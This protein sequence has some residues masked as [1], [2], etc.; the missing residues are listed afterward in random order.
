MI[1]ISFIIIFP[2]LIGK[3]Y[4][5]NYSILKY[6]L[7]KIETI[8]ISIILLLTLNYQ[9]SVFAIFVLVLILILRY[10]KK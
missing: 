4:K 6:D 7:T 9:N 8:V 1:T 3:N 5:M 2:Y 10:D